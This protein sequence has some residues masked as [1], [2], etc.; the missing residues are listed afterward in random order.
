MATITWVCDC[1]RE[2]EHPFEDRFEGPSLGESLKILQK[3]HE[4]GQTGLMCDRSDCGNKMY[5]VRIAP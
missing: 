2:L 3:K 1:G 4:A 5:P